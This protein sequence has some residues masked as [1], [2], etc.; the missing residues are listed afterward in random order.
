MGG[1]GGR[2]LS[3]SS[4]AAARREAHDYEAAFRSGG[5]VADGGAARRDR[6]RRAAAALRRPVFSTQCTWPR[7]RNTQEPGRDRRRV[8]SPAHIR[9]CPARMQSTSSY[10]MEVV[11]RAAGRD[12]AH[13]LRDL[14]AADASSSTSTRYQRSPVISAAR[15]ASR[16][17]RPAATAHRRR[18]GRAA[19]RTS[20]SSAPGIG[21]ARADERQR[22]GP[23]VVEGE[24]RAAAAGRRPYPA[25]RARRWPSR[26]D[27]A[28][29]L[30]DEQHL[31]AGRRCAGRATSAGRDLEDAQRDRLGARTRA[32]RAARSLRPPC[33]ARLAFPQRASRGSRL[34]ASVGHPRMYAVPDHPG[35][36]R[37]G[38]PQGDR[39]RRHQPG[40]HPLRPGGEEAGISPGR[41]RPRRGLRRGLP[42]PHL[43]HRALPARRRRA[44]GGASPPSWARRCR[45]SASRS[46][47]ATAWTRRSTRRPQARP[48]L[49][50]FTRTPPRGEAAL[51][52]RSA[53]AR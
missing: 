11:R 20:R 40:L 43:R 22:P 15:S 53:T 3:S 19:A 29:A 16:T 41:G 23:G 31:V 24:A 25:R 7:G 50:L 4:A 32:P 52:R 49:E 2:P 5:V 17:N 42:H 6:R 36:H 51:P 27:G 9:P 1:R 34:R 48:S 8:V 13:E 18:G 30:E 28:V 47:R 45:R 10:S 44:T 21:T 14:R 35:G 37:G 33:C 12:R 38:R 26:Y 39:H 46:W